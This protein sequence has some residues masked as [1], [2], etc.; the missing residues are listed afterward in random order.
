MANDNNDL[1]TLAGK[2]LD[3]SLTD[4]EAERLET[5]LSDPDAAEFF[6]ANVDVDALMENLALE[7]KLEMD[8]DVAK[9]A[10]KDECIDCGICVESCPS[11]AIE[12]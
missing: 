9:T 8:G 4:A 2:F 6:N 3:A 11:G 1:P 12:E 7:R 10:S 5:L